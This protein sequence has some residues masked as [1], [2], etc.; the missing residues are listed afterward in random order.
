MILLILASALISFASITLLMNAY[1]APATRLKIAG[2][3]AGR[4]DFIIHVTVIL[5]F[6]GTSTL[7]L[8]QAELAA[9]M[10]TL[11]NRYFY[12]WYK[13]AMYKNSK[14]DWYVT[15]GWKP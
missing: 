6:I 14:G 11:Y 4:I 9:I 3:W 1:C 7:G 15:K 13:G 8:L 2:Q 5:L 10:F 12:R